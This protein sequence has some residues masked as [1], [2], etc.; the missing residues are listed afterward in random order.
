VPLPV[1]V[2]EPVDRPIDVVDGGKHSGD[3]RGVDP[4]PRSVC[5]ELPE[6]LA[7]LVLPAEEPESAGEADPVRSLID[8]DGLL[9]LTPGFEDG[10]DACMSR[11]VQRIQLDSITEVL[12][13]FIGPL[14]RQEC[15]AV[16]G[17]PSQC[18]SMR[19]RPA[20]RN[21]DE[22]LNF[23][24]STGCT[25]TRVDE[26]AGFTTISWRPRCEHR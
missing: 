7:G 19:V 16:S 13:R 26:R 22:A 4:R 2:L 15:D 24:V 17:T 20:R 8:A 1:G 14:G 25:G 3:P 23:D 21:R 18:A 9:E 10:T 5:L 12:E 6:D 11:G